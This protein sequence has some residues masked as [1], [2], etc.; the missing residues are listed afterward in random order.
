MSPDMKK[1]VEWLIRCID[2]ADYFEIGVIRI[3]PIIRIK[4]DK[5]R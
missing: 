3:D 2:T 1:Q 4:E 5:R